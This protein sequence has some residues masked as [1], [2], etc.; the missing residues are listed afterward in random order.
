MVDKCFRET[1]ILFRQLPEG[2][3]VSFVAVTVVII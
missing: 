2:I 3:R 1:R